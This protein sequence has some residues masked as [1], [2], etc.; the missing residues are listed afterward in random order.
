LTN[1]GSLL[2]QLRYSRE[3]EHEADAH[4]L[5][6]LK[7]ANISPKPFSGSSTGCSSAMPG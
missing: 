3:A 1:A 7:V 4:A 2:L 5:E 6:I